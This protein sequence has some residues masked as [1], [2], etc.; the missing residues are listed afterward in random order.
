[1]ETINNIELRDENIFPDDIVLKSILNESFQVYKKL[2]ELFTKYEMD[3][4]WRYYHD[5]KAWLCKVQKK[6]KT[7]VWMSAWKDFMQATIYF[8]E[9]NIDKIYDLNINEEIKQKIRSTKELQLYLQH[10]KLLL[11]LLYFV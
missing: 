10:N 7:I 6:K 2:L 11:L 9:R 1:M 8:P 3:Y 4:E 5:G